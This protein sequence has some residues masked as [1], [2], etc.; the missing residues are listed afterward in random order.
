[1]AALRDAATTAETMI[2]TVGKRLNDKDGIDDKLVMTLDDFDKSAKGLT[3]L[4]AR[5]DGMLQESRA[6]VRDFSQRGLGEAA[7]LVVDA[8]TLVAEL[9]RIAG[10]FE[11][12]PA[13]FLLGDRREG[14]QPR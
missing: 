10:Q 12:D 8:R 13:R 6:G 5:L 1:M 11:R 7:Q 3:Q 9:N 4:T 14:Y 2:S